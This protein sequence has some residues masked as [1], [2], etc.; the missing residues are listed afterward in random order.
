MQQYVLTRNDRGHEQNHTL[1]GLNAMTKREPVQYGLEVVADARLT[2][3]HDE[4]K[5]NTDSGHM[6]YIYARKRCDIQACQQS[7]WKPTTLLT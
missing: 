4:T 3:N 5:N 6:E 2:A 7:F 1:I